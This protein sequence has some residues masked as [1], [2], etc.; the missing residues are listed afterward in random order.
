MK[1][2]Q[3]EV[4]TLRKQVAEFEESLRVLENPPQYGPRRGELAPLDFLKA[5]LSALEGEEER[6]RLLAIAYKSLENA[7][8]QLA[9]KEGEL[10]RLQ[11]DCDAIASEMTAAGRSVLET[12]RAYREA[13]A[14]FETLAAKHQRRWSELNPGQELYRRLGRI[15]FPGFLLSRSCGTLTTATI[16]RDLK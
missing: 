16:A 3:E 13:L 6:K 10:E 11:S 8:Q 5:E 4:Q 7:R 1:T 14:N 2:L 9:I 15:E 12:E